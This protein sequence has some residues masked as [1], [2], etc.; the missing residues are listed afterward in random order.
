MSVHSTVLWITD[1]VDVSFDCSK[2]V[3][4]DDEYYNQ[5]N[6][7]ADR[8]NIKQTYKDSEY[9]YLKLKSFSKYPVLTRYLLKDIEHLE[10]DYEGVLIT[11]KPKSET[12]NFFSSIHQNNW[13]IGE[14][15]SIDFSFLIG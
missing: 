7:Y 14:I 15:R 10:D 13:K 3:I 6:L 5:L 9:F 1:I 2:P 8:E 12:Y 11:F 4:I